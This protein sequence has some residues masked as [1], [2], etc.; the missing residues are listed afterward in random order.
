MKRC[1]FLRYAL[2]TG[3]T[4][5]LAGSVLQSVTA[6]EVN[7]KTATNKAKVQ[8]VSAKVSGA[9]DTVGV[10]TKP[11][12]GYTSEE[13]TEILARAGYNAIDLAFRKGGHIEPAAGGAALAAFV[14]I[15]AKAGLTVPMA[16]TD[17]ISADDPQT[18]TIIKAMADNG[19]K[20]YRF[21]EFKYDMKR[22][23]ADNLDLFRARMEKL[24]ELNQRIGIRGELQNHVGVRFGSPVW[25][26]YLVL[27]DID[28]R[29]VGS[30]YDIRHAVAEGMQ[31]WELA[32]RAIADR[33]GTICIKDF[34]WN[35]LPN[36]SFAPL[37][38]PM[39]DGIVDFDRYFKV[40]D[41]L[42]VRCPISVH[43]EYP[44]LTSDE[45]KLPKKEQIDRI[46]AALSR[47]LAVLQKYVK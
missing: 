43:I 26:E 9:W 42:G 34:T 11:L 29:Y 38:V 15:A 23:I 25:D 37:T 14:K 21:G 27:R 47:D 5:P 45:E 7:K 44:M 24:G 18:A 40:L 31:S 30:Q 22:S 28:S 19:I 6:E 10:F 4:V 1:E 2:M 46:V 8:P 39:G 32:L 33:I 35:K 17:I 36:G 20:H 3:A 13:I 41:E 16:V 12:D